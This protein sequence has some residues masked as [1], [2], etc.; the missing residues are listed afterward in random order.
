MSQMDTTETR[1]LKVGLV[2]SGGGAKAMAHIGLLKVME[3][4]GLRPDRIAGTSMGSVVGALFAMGYS[5]EKI[6]AELR[7]IDWTRV[8]TNE[9]PSA[10]LP[11]IDK[12]AEE[13]YL[14]SFPIEDRQL[15]LPTGINYGQSILINLARLTVPAHEIRDFSKLPIPFSCMATDLE[16]GAPVVLDTGRLADAL[17][18]STSFPTLYSPYRIGNRML[19]DGGLVSN[20]PS[21]LLADSVDIIIGSDVQ[22]EAYKADDL[23]S[24]LKVLEQIS[25][26]VNAESYHRDTALAEILVRPYV[27]GAGITTFDLFD[28]IVRSGYRAAEQHRL[29]IRAIAQRKKAPVWTALPYPEP[30]GKWYISGA[31]LEQ[32][33]G[34]PDH[35]LK[36]KL[37]LSLPDSLT[38]RDIEIGMNRL[39]GRGVYRTVDYRFNPLQGD[40]IELKIRPKERNPK[41][42]LRFG[43]HYDID[44]QTALLVNFTRRDFLMDYDRLKF[45]VAIGTLP[46][47]WIDYRL[48]RDYIPSVGFKFRAYRLEPRLYAEGKSFLSFDY[49]DVSANV[50]FLTLVAN[51]LSLEAGVQYENIWI[52]DPLDVVFASNYQ[53][54]YVNYY[55]ELKIDFL[56]RISFPR[57][58]FL[59]KSEF[60]MITQS[61]DYSEL[62]EPG[63]VLDLSFLQALRFGKRWFAHAR[64]ELATTIGP[65]QNYE[66]SLFLGGLGQNYIQYSR[67][68]AGY[69]FM[70]LTGRNLITA[71]LDLHYE[72]YADH[73]LIA[74]AN[75]GKLENNLESQ[76]VSN[77][78]LDGYAFSYAYLSPVG[79]LQLSVH[80]STNHPWVYT[81]VNLGFWF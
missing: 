55:G 9:K 29:A 16:T 73:L 7:S 4:E 35:Y 19:V 81:Y 28:S 74:K 57:R 77:V 38:L 14:I 56:E 20:F 22:D 75:I 11:L 3:E 50:F 25:S 72:F 63:S 37:G 17:R 62:F 47:L 30:D 21:S 52:D 2:L 36:H 1:E 68:F 18:A 64:A 53:N 70:E 6:E 41:A 42:L 69:Q 12:G 46:R 80:G 51:R 39:Y 5:A 76:S 26:F 15:K 61:Q 44:F 10:Y 45:D 58:G 71:G 67:P 49:W 24:I 23:N 66:Y 65:D 54:N 79:P 34:I 13:R 43:L 33:E 48:D 40:S 59:F 60:R 31:S 8:L 32:E 78:L 27:P